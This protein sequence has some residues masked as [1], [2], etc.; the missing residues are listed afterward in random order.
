MTETTKK[1]LKEIEAGQIAPAFNKIILHHTATPREAKFD[2]EWCRRLHKG[3]G[4]R[5]IGYHYYI[6]AD[7][8]F[9]FGRPARMRGA[10]TLGQNAES[11]GIAYCGGLKNGKAHFTMTY[12]QSQTI[13]VLIERLRDVTNK[14]LPL[15]GHREFSATF[16]PGFDVHDITAWPRP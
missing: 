5:D 3:K 14:E 16:C 8:E 11:I 4:W 6:D 15:Y 10:H 2:V 12:E 7:G 13:T 9:H 1:R